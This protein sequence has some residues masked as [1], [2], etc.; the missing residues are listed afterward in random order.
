MNKHRKFDKLGLFYILALSTIALSIIISQI[1]VQGFIRKQQDDSRTINVAGRQRML[2]QKISKLALRVGQTENKE[3]LEVITTELKEATDLWVSSHLALL[4]GDA[5]LGLEGNPSPPILKKYGD[6]ENDYLQIVK[7]AQIITSSATSDD[8]TLLLNQAI[9]NILAHEARFLEGM[10]Q[11]VFEYD[12]E[13]NAKV[14][15]LRKIEIGLLTF[16]LLIIAIELIFIFRPIA[17]NVRRTVDELMESE[18]DSIKLASEL[19]RLYE[20][21]AKSYQ[22]LESTSYE[23]ETP[24]VFAT[25]NTKG[26]FTLLSS[27]FREL[28]EWESKETPKSFAQLLID[29][30]YQEE[31]VKGLMDI[32]GQNKPWTGELKFTNTDGDFVW[33]ELFIIPSYVNG[34]YDNKIIARNITDAK[35][36]KM[37]SREINREKI[38]EK[39]KEQQYRSVLI[40]EGQEEERQ[41]LGRE[42]HDG[43]GQ[44]LTALK[45]SLESITPNSSI[46]T[47]KRLEDARE[48]M[49]SII[50][51]VR[52]IAFNLT[53]TSLSDFGVVPAIRKFCKE[54]STF[55]GIEVVFENSTRFVNRLDGHVE[56]NI[57]RIV[58]EGVNNAIKYA[59][60]TKIKV[61]TEHTP[62]ELKITI[63][64]D[65]KGFDYEK[66][67]NS[68][69]FT[70]SGH[71]IFNMKERT[72]F[73]NGTFERESDLGKG[74]RIL[75]S[76]PLD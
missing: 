24:L 29:N 13:A 62:K 68:N 17:R 59:K 41:R 25:M 63:A 75:I 52:K 5:E 56:N 32:L 38:E 71:G 18:Q 8:S 12:K 57:Y 9:E 11:I 28:M 74:T 2:S 35:E 65:G 21:L 33:L 64:D 36:A 15:Q 3:N 14:E 43:L 72:A 4:E 55:S 76:I 34:Q 7:S 53:P 20:Q 37:R 19:S 70:Q 73:I 40:L 45:L 47:K 69:Y 1:V 16:S 31:F 60:A 51:E 42:I 23:P 49:K 39:V 61:Q 67:T 10:D 27:K 66:L 6:I 22:D 46:H 44:M 58:Q 48:L 30:G 50:R 26:H 54:V